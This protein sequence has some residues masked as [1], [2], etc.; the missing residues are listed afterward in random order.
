M[1]TAPIFVGTPKN[2]KVQIVAADASAN[3]TVVTVGTNGSKIISLNLQSDDTSARDVR[4]SIV[5]GG[6]T[7]P[8]GVVT[9]PIGAGAS[10]TVPS[11]NALDLSKIPGLPIDTDG[12]PFVL[13]ITGDTFVVNA[14]T[15]VTAAKTITAIAIYG[16][17]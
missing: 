14:L 4:V 5:N 11:V 13:L 15:T 7:Y 9:V 8:L 16:D 12:N 2:G 17:F 1:A 6:T 10:G 3:K